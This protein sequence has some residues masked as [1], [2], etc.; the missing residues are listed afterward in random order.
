MQSLLQVSFDPLV[1]SI[2]AVLGF[3]LGSFNTVLCYRIPREIP[4]GLFSHRRSVCSSCKKVIPWHQNIPIFAYLFLRGACRQC[5]AKIPSRYFWIEVTTLLS[6][7]AT[8][9][10]FENSVLKPEESATYWAE[11]TK[12]LYFTLSLVAVVFIDLEFRIIPDRFSIGNWVIAAVASFAWGFP[13]LWESVAGGLLGFGMFFFMAF[14]YEKIK[15]IEGLGF[16]DVKMMGWLG[17]WLGVAS[18]PI[19]ILVGSLTGLMAGLWAMRSSKEGLQ[20]AIPF[21]PFLAFGAYVAWVAQSL[22]F[23]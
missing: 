3:L 19:V 5:S 16:G 15:K 10:V 14:V 13:P 7:V 4:L 22:G 1:L 12:N 20:T 2:V 18:V 11:L 23:I 8:Y 21:G 17:A 6:F 9:L